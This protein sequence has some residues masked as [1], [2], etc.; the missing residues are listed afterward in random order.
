[1]RV[2]WEKE[3][4]AEKITVSPR[5]V[6]KCR[7]CPMYGKRPSCP[8]YAPDWKEAKEWVRSFKK[9]LLVKFEVD[10]NDFEN[11]K[12]KVLLWLLKK[13]AELFKR[14]SSTQWPFSQATAT[15]ATTVH[16]STVSHAGCLRR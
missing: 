8:P 9:A 6:W 2:V 7:T 13:E 1:M 11:E 14:G 4:P 16:L 5:P 3:I 15:S 12:R 10:M